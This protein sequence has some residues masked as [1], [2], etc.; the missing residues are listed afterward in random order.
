MQDFLNKAGKM[1]VEIANKAGSKAEELAEV[2]KL[3]VKINSE[4]QEVSQLK[5]QIG[6]YC[7]ELFERDALEDETII[8]ICAKI[9][10]HLKAIETMEEQ[11]QEVKNEYKS[12]SDTGDSDD[13]EELK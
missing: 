8:E 13:A 4:K 9:K 12:K 11:A 3:K 5:K 2:G 7:C 10:E 1:A 6:D